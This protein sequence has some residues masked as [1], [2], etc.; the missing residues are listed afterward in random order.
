MC[1]FRKDSARRLGRTELADSRQRGVKRAA[2]NSPRHL[3]VLV[4]PA[5]PRYIIIPVDVR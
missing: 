1:L 4:L 5:D 3:N 2:G